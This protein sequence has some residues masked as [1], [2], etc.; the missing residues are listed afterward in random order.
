M[1]S[2]KVK[3]WTGEEQLLTKEEFI[4]KWT[5]SV[6]DYRYL[7]D[8]SDRENTKKMVDEIDRI[9]YKLA[10]AKFDSIATESE[11]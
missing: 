8:S 6:R 9:V 1:G 10:A 5:D 7:I 2:I 11:K 3:K 4:G